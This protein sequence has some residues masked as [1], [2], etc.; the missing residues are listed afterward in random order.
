MLNGDKVMWEHSDDDETT[1]ISTMIKRGVMVG[2]MCTST[3]PSPY[4]EGYC[5]GWEA[6]V[7]FMATYMRELVIAFVANP[8]HP[9][10]AAYCCCTLY[11]PAV[12]DADTHL[13]KLEDW[14]EHATITDRTPP[15]PIK[16]IK[17]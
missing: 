13:P 15:S 4:K 8:S 3:G 16:S 17:P 6:A 10:L 2:T 11:E 7:N 5:D 14:R 1:F 12:D 9:D